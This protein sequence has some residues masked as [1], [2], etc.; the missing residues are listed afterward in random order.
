MLHSFTPFTRIRP[1]HS[2]GIVATEELQRYK[3][4]TTKVHCGQLVPQ[5]VR[6]HSATA[7]YV[8][9]AQLSKTIEP[10]ALH[11][12]AI[13]HEHAI[14]VDAAR[15]LLEAPTCVLRV[16]IPLEIIP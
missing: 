1:L 14:H 5:H 11:R 12:V 9:I 4:L 3:A 13:S 15:K 10:K 2:R 16:T 8:T 7:G 6:V